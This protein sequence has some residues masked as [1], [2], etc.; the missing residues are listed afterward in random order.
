MKIVIFK[1]GHMDQFWQ[2]FTT[3]FVTKQMVC[4]LKLP[5][6]LDGHRTSN[7]TRNKGSPVASMATKVLKLFQNISDIDISGITHAIES[8][9]AKAD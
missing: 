9:W 8:P 3:S 6:V 5:L 4:I 7:F 2:M 1:H